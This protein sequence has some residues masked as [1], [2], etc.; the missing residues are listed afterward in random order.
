MICKECLRPIPSLSIRGVKHRAVKKTRIPK[1]Y[2]IPDDAEALYCLPIPLLVV[3]TDKKGV[4][5]WKSQ[6]KPDLH[7]RLASPA[8]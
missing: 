1:R 8:A 5:K 7:K 2:I 6:S 4:S 3:E